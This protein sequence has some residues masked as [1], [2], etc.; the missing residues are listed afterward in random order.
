MIGMGSIARNRH[1]A[2]LRSH[3]VQVAIRAICDADPAA[4]ERSRADVPEA[5]AYTDS[6]ALLA[7]PAIDAVLLALPNH[8]HLEGCRQAAA[9][10][11]HILL[12]KPIAR[13]PAEADEV[14]AAAR[15]AGVMLMIAHSDRYSPVFRETKRLLDQG[16][17]G[18]VIALH[19]DH[20]SN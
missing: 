17:L 6:R 15:Q 7:D 3:A 2:A 16:A 5:D 14:I 11:K 19:V 13:T 8:L 18:E 1:V 9:A 12:E 20:Y 4:V 10:G